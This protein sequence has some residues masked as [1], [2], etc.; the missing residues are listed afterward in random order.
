MSA[1]LR[2]IIFDVDGTLVDS[3]NSI[4]AAMKAA[5]AALDMP[6]P[7][8]AE[9]LGIVGL[10]LEVAMARLAPGRD[11]ACHARLADAYR[12]S[13]R[14]GRERGDLPPLFPGAR[15]VL[16]RLAGVPENILGI[17]TGKSA[18]GLAALIGAH[19]LDGVF[20]T[21]QVADHHPSKPHPS[22]IETAMAEAGVGPGDTVMIGDTSF[23]IDMAR[24]ARVAAIGV[25]WGYHPAPALAAADRVIEDFE[26]LPRA[27]D[28][29]WAAR[30]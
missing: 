23:D 7:P 6:L 10:S 27:L 28:D 21:T 9:L 3:Q 8:R 16:D 20:A 13:F 12:D 1:P 30:Q 14:S 25:D 17:A 19:G 26:A 22:M 24:A 11:P 2:L 5:F 15:A 29:I 18:R 4:V